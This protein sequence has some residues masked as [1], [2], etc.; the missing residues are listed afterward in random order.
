MDGL[1][2][3]VPFYTTEENQRQ[4]ELFDNLPKIYTPKLCKI[5]DWR[6][7]EIFYFQDMKK[8]VKN[9]I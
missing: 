7:K 3:T 5:K 9:E 1:T 8:G 2:D 6:Q 4:L